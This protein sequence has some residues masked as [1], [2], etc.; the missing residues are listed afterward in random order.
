MEKFR[1]HE[2]M[3]KLKE[4]SVK[5]LQLTKDLSFQDDDDDEDF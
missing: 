5:G 1:E 3:F 4:F 2:K